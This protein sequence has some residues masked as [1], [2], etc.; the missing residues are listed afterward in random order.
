[1]FG[2]GDGGT[3]AALGPRGWVAGDRG[4]GESGELRF[5]LGEA[6]V[7]EAWVGTAL[8]DAAPLE[9]GQDPNARGV[10]EI[11][12]VG[13]VERGELVEGDP[14]KSPTG[15]ELSVVGLDEHAVQGE[16]VEVRVEPEVGAHALHDGDGAAL[17][18]AHAID[19][20]SNGTHTSASP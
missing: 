3:L 6:V 10:Q 18:F 13:V 19:D 16:E 12:D 5:A 9:E 1:V 11:R 8:D 20:S 7:G 17:V 15:G 4:G 2:Q 14:G